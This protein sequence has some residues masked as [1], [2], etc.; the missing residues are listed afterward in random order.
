MRRFL[1]SLVLVSCSALADDMTDANKF[2]AAKEYG[3]ALPLYTRLANAGN[4]E[5]QL[6]VGEMLWFGDGTAQDLVAAR[7]WFEKSAAAGNVDARESLAALDLRKTRGGEIDYW[8]TQ[9]DGADLTAG[10]FACALPAIP[11]VSK[12]SAEVAAAR[13]GIENWR[14]CYDGFAANFNATAPIGKRIPAEVLDMMTPQEAER[15][16]VHVESVYGKVLA[17]AQA[18]A[19]SVQ[20]RQVAWEGATERFFTEENVRLARVSEEQKRATLDA[21]RRALTEA[22]AFDRRTMPQPTQG[23]R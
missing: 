15:A 21:Q 23:A 5:A 10:K 17:K 3:K 20:A 7:R 6:R 22:G 14:T 11:A 1:M 18:D 8:T 13:Q 12:T 9:Y 16:R 19:D 4:S 2:L